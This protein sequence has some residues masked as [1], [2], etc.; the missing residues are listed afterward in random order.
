[1]NINAAEPA[2]DWLKMTADFLFVSNDRYVKYLGI[3]TYS[4][5]HNMCPAVEHV[6]LFVMDC[7]ITGENKARL[8]HQAARFD[9]AEIIFY[10]IERKLDE[11]VPKIPNN[12]NPAIYGRLFL[13]EILK[14]YDISRLVYFDCDLLMDRPVTELFTMQLDGRCIAG[15]SDG[16][17]TLRKKALGID[18][19]YPYI[20]SGVLVI[21][22]ARWVEMDAST[23]VIDYINSFPDKL[24][25]PDQDAINYIMRDE[26][27]LLDP[28]YNMLLMLCERDIPI[29][30]HQS[31]NYIYNEE[32]TVRALYHGNIY[33]FAGHD[34]WSFYSITPAHAII[35]KKYRRLCDWRN[36]KRKFG[37]LRNFALWSLV[38]LKRLLIGEFSL[39]RKK[40]NEKIPEQ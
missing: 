18:S 38:S 17:S 5:M 11:I 29:I 14:L 40:M 25:Y 30:L 4:V 33:H 2:E 36:E 28:K 7:G 6:R 13:T 20:N 26:I 37:G 24:V 19:R 34:M 23:K 21:D 39:T 31:E 16:E 10:N 35:F 3:C 9:N 12:W 22:T 8:A 15:V 1:M 32:Q 27:K